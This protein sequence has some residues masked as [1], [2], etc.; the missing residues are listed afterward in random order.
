M[1]EGTEVRGIEGT[2]E[3]TEVIFLLISLRNFRIAG[4]LWSHADAG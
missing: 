1:I 2:I 4:L 3:G